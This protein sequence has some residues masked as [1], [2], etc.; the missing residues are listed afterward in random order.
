M[1][2]TVLG[3]LYGSWSAAVDSA[4]AAASELAGEEATALAK[5]AAS[6]FADVTG[7]VLVTQ[8][9]PAAEVAMDFGTTTGSDTT[10]V[11]ASAS[12]MDSISAATNSITDSLPTGSLLSGMTSGFETLQNQLTGMSA[13]MGK[14]STSMQFASHLEYT[15]ILVM[16]FGFFL[17]LLRFANWKLACGFWLLS[18]VVG[19]FTLYLLFFRSVY[20]FMT[21]FVSDSA[22]SSCLILSIWVLHEM[23]LISV[24]RVI[25]WVKVDFWEKWV[26]MNVNKLLD[27]TGDG[28]FDYQDVGVLVQAAAHEM[29]EYGENAFDHAK[30]VSRGQESVGKALSG[31]LLFSPA[32]SPAASPAD[33][34]GKPD[35]TVPMTTRS[36][37][38]SARVKELELKLAASEKKREELQRQYDS[39]VGVLTTELQK[40]APTSV[41]SKSASKTSSIA[42]KST[43][44]GIVAC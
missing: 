17:F 44:D 11:A 7:G 4:T 22:A 42:S 31:A 33:A 15:G 18:N 35:G 29:A 37:G 19:S 36:P 24:P 13:T 6:N 32:G 43:T 25:R 5:A 8:T 38:D 27:V 10:T 34:P 12:I 9:H 26:L 1:S 41:T 28:K 2:D 40:Q 23:N 14:I 30:R 16:K 39:L 20:Y 3:S 21:R